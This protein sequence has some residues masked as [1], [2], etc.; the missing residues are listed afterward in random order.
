MKEAI[1]QEALTIVNIY[2][3]KRRALQFIKQLITNIK[4]LI[5]NNKVIGEE[6]N[7]HLQQWKDNMSRTSTRTQ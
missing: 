7:I 6:F 2:A 3:P 1:Q 4:E 5:G